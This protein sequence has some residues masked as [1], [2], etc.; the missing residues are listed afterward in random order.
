LFK[1]SSTKKSH[2]LILKDLEV[3]ISFANCIPKMGDS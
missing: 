3:F 2:H 1:T